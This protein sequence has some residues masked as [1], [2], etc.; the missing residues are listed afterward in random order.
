MT[1]RLAPHEARHVPDAQMDALG[2]GLPLLGPEAFRYYLPRFIEF[3]LLHRDSEAAAYIIYNLAP[4]PDLDV[5]PRNRFLYFTP[6][7]REALRKYIE[8]RIA[9]EDP[10][11]DQPI[12]EELEKALQPWPDDV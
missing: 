5:G 4:D 9:I 8:Y 3:S 11:I 1:S 10:E 2:G 7:E 12:I 6:E